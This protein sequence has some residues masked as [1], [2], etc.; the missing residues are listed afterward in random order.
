MSTLYL[1]LCALVDETPIANVSRNTTRLRTLR[2]LLE[3]PHEAIRGF[4]FLVLFILIWIL[5][6]PIALDF[7]GEAFLRATRSLTA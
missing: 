6:Q 7:W 2:W 1:L 4:S 5:K 3:A